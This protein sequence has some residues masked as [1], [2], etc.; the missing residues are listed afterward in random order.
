MSLAAVKNKAGYKTTY[1][2]LPN[3]AAAVHGIY[4]YNGNKQMEIQLNT[5]HLFFFLRFLSFSN[6]WSLSLYDFIRFSGKMNA[7]MFVPS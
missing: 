6:C 2:V 7:V 1:P 3:E 4:L 5:A